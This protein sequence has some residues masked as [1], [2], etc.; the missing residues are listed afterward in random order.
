MSVKY[1]RYKVNEDF[2]SSYD[3]DKEDNSFDELLV[4]SANN[5]INNYFG[6]IDFVLNFINYLSLF[7]RTEFITFFE[8]VTDSER[9]RKDIKTFIY[10]TTTRLFTAQYD[11]SHSTTMSKLDDI[12]NFVNTKKMQAM[13]K[14]Y[15][16]NYDIVKYL[17]INEYAY[18]FNTR[19]NEAIH[20]VG[21]RPISYEDIRSYKSVSET[22]D[23][24]GYN[25]GK[26][27]EANRAKF[28]NYYTDTHHKDEIEYDFDNS[29]R[30]LLNFNLGCTFNIWKK[31]EFNEDN[32][33]SM[34]YLNP[35]QPNALDKCMQENNELI[36]KASGGYIDLRFVYHC[37]YYTR[38][39]G[40]SKVLTVKYPDNPD[41]SP[42]AQ[43]N[44]AVEEFKANSVLK[45]EFDKIENALNTYISPAIGGVKFKIS[46]Y[47]YAGPKSDDGM[48]TDRL[49]L[50]HNKKYFF[51]QIY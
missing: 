48:V 7:K 38:S 17:T 42:E 37:N 13:I 29:V 10:N 28:V 6:Y 8:S 44:M 30:P 51:E 11:A 1:I 34:I 47:L 23:K 45:Q 5:T 22:T 20:K 3:D 40:F 39:R 32:L 16:E 43:F 41:F 50:L 33:K 36:S 46:T 21:S 35:L 31:W 25:I 27:F 2:V 26:G 15:Q 9:Y 19:R 4:N 49:M 12:N 14:F 24:I 18:V